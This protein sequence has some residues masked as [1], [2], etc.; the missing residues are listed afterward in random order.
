MD[1][2]TIK[3]L[4]ERLEL[5]KRTHI[6]QAESGISDKDSFYYRG[7]R[8]GFSNGMDR[9]IETLKTELEITEG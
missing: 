3:T 8:D 9:A 6:H 7:C 2:A 4:I 5:V 1:K